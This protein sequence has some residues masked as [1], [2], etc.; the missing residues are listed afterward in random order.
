MGQQIRPETRREFL[1]KLVIP[2]DPQVGNPNLIFSEPFKPGQP[3]FNRAYEASFQELDTKKFS[4]GIKD[5][6]EAVMFYFNDAYT[7]R[8]FSRIRIHIHHQTYAATTLI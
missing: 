3:E 7:K 6:D 8:V 5:I 2:T 1:D 4:I